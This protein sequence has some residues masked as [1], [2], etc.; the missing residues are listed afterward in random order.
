ML[1]QCH[2]CGMRYSLH[3]LGIGPGWSRAEFE[4]LGVPFTGRCPSLGEDRPPRVGNPGDVKSVGSGISELRIDYGP[5]YRVYYLQDG[6]RLVLLL[7]GG[8]KSTQ[9]NDIEEAHI[10]AAEWKKDEQHD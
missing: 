2:N 8:D 10:I 5:G 9:R 4:A 7:C 6:L 1:P 3:A